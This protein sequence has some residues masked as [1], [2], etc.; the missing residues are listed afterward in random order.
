MSRTHFHTST[1]RSRPERPY[2]AA[3]QRCPSC[4]QEN[5]DGANFCLSCATPLRVQRG[6]QER[7]VVTVVFCDLVGFT[8]RAETMD[9]EDVRALLSPYHSRLR[10]ELELYGGTVEKFIGD[11]VVAV[12]GAPLAHED[13]PERAV[14]ASLAIRDWARNSGDVEVRI[15]VNTGPALVTVEADSARGEGIVAG[16]VINTAARLQTAAPVNGVLVGELCYRATRDAIVYA[17]RDVI[18]A[19]GKADP[20]PVWEALEAKKRLGSAAELDPRTPFVGRER[21]LSVLRDAFERARYEHEPQL[22]TLVAVPGSGK[23]RLV[24]ELSRM[25]DDDPERITWRQGR[26]LSYGEGV[27][28][29]A[30]AEIVKAEIGILDNDTSEVAAAKLTSGTGKLLPE[31]DA[32]WVEKWLRPL[33]GLGQQETLHG[34]Q[35]ETFPAWRRFLEAIAERGPTVLVVED[36]HWADDGLLNFVDELLEWTT[37]LP[38]LLIATARPELLG[39]RPNWGGGKPNAVTLSLPPLSETE[40]AQLLQHLLDRSVVDADVQRTLLDR[41][42]GNP[43]YAEE[44]ARIVAERG[45]AELVVPESVHGI[46]TARLD[47]LQPAEKTLLQDAAVLGTTFWVGALTA[48]GQCERGDIEPRLRELE[49]REFVRRSR[50]SSVDGEA[51]YAFRHDLVRETAYEQIPRAERSVRHERAAQWISAL[52]RTDDHAE[53]LA[54]HYLEAISYA[55][56]AGRDVSDFAGAARAAM[57]EAGDRAQRLAAYRQAARFFDAALDLGPDDE[58][59]R[60]ALLFRSGSAKFW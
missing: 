3:M 12:F 25:L 41:A 35:D 11:A 33:V 50:H 5:P 47:A 4:G 48:L 28:F 45:A 15:A 44:F 36:L 56:A 8:G 46:V 31:A 14:R 53:L 40:T 29:W 7:K 37:G 39:R 6:R 58:A 54:H 18:D 13:D 20:V 34:V 52:G 49:R 42:G 1:G 2:A 9:P 30:L 26:C 32:A 60:A 51:E 21:E 24:H 43:L 16:D 19:K 59:E 55:Q 38:L 17:E 27:T 57:R 10:A 23:S 22:V